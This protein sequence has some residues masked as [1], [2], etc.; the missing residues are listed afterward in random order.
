MRPLALPPRPHG[1]LVQPYSQSLHKPPRI[2]T[3]KRPPRPIG[4][5]KKIAERIGHEPSPELALSLLNALLPAID[6]EPT[7]YIHVAT[8]PP[9][10]SPS[11]SLQPHSNSR[12]K[13]KPPTVPSSPFQLTVNPNSVV[14]PISSS[15]H[16]SPENT[17]RRPGR[18]RLSATITPPSTPPPCYGR[19]CSPRFRTD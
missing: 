11:I 10:L 3:I 1:F 12:S 8:V 2:E 7:A 9:A 18:P 6:P 17:P 4:P 14:H 5:R 16:P 15:H 19:R 13:K